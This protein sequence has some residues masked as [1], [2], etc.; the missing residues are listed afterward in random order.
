MM[1]NLGPRQVRWLAQ[2]QRNRTRTVCI[3]HTRAFDR[4]RLALRRLVLRG[5]MAG[6]NFMTA[7]FPG[8][9]LY[10]YALT[11]SGAECPLPKER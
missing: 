4:D 5:L 11:P 3:P 8:G 9:G 6:P 1:R 2:A 7:N 10:F